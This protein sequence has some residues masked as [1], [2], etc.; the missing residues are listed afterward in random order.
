MLL[1]SNYNIMIFTGL[2]GILQWVTLH[3]ARKKRMTTN[4]HFA[5]AGMASESSR[6]VLLGVAKFETSTLPVQS[7]WFVKL[8]IDS[9]WILFGTI[10]GNS[11]HMANVAGLWCVG[12]MLCTCVG[13]LLSGDHWQFKQ[14]HAATVCKHQLSLNSDTN[15]L[16]FS[17]WITPGWRYNVGVLAKPVP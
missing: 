1:I 16:I 7:P 9:I 3:R 4:R 15:W 2:G 5:K 11:C 17:R 10:N 13:D 8:K 12:T 14:L 6:G